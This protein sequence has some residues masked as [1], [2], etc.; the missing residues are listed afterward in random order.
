MT[1]LIELVSIRMTP[2]VVWKLASLAGICATDAK[3]ARDA[4][5]PTQCDG[6]RS[7]GAPEAGARR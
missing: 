4:I 3:R 7:M 5:G 1:S 6:R 2:E